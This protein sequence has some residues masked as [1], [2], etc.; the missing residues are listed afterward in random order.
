VTDALTVST[1]AGLPAVAAF[2]QPD[3]DRHVL[4]QL[5]FNVR[6]LGGL[7]A[8]GGRAVRPGVL[9][10]GDGI[11]R[12]RSDDVAALRELGLRTVLDLRTDG[13]LTTHGAFRGEGVVHHHLPVLRETWDTRVF[14]PTADHDAVVAFL[15]DRYVE[16]LDEGGDALA[17]AIRAI[18]DPD[19]QAVLFHC[20][21]GKDRT[22]VVAMLVLGLLGVVDDDVADDYHLTQHGTSRWLTWAQEAEPQM[23]E[24]MADQPVAYLASP[25]EA[26]LSLLDELRRRHGSVEGYVAGIGVDEGTIARLRATLLD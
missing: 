14:D 20:A 4:L 19:N 9:Y 18:A 10:R 26:A 3:H 1:A 25:R 17:G 23:L 8:D 12:L 22:G 24:A 15:T 16:M 7:P 13:E 21:A 2:D 11:H 5:A 6:D